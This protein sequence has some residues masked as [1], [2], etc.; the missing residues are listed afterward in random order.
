MG[1]HEAETAG[2]PA[3]NVLACPRE[4]LARCRGPGLEDA[5]DLRAPPLHSVGVGAVQVDAVRLHARFRY[6]ACCFGH[7]DPS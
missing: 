2:N 1:T 3:R 5:F 4:R 6:A 7:P